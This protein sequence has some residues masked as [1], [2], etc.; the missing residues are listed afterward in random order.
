M[1]S[2][3]MT[4]EAHGI[5]TSKVTNM[6]LILQGYLVVFY[7]NHTNRLNDIKYVYPMIIRL[8][9]MLYV[10]CTWPCIESVQSVSGN[11]YFQLYFRVRDGYIFA[12]WTFFFASMDMAPQLHKSIN[13]SLTLKILILEESTRWAWRIPLEVTSRTKVIN[14]HAT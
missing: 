10:I 3:F 4:Y 8:R 9:F 2:T 12:G 11:L 14:I 13:K 1:L 7:V 6:Q 5:H